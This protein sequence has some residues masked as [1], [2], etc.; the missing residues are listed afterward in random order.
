MIRMV[1]KVFTA[2]LYRCIGMKSTRYICSINKLLDLAAGV[3]NVSNCG[4][5]RKVDYKP[6]GCYIIIY[7]TCGNGHTFQWESFERLGEGQHQ[8]QLHVDNLH[9]ASAIVLSGNNYSKIEQ[10]ARI[11]RLNIIS[12]SVF[13]GYQCNYI[14]TGV[15]EYYKREQVRI[16]PFNNNIYLHYRKKYL[17]SSKTKT[18]LLLGMADAIPQDCQPSFA[19]ILLWMLIHT[20]YY[21]LRP[22]TNVKLIYIP[23]IWTKKLS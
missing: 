15:K 20:K 1:K 16:L 19:H 21:I 9:F 8:K 10:L 13:Q 2:F 17:L 7:G 5:Q 6:S 4:S 3:C 18:W 22:L 11:F 23:L 12:H 14:C